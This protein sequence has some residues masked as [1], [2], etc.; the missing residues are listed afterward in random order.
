MKKLLFILLILMFASS[1]SATVYKWADEGGVMNFTDDYSK[2]PPDYR[3]KAEQVTVP[4]AARSTPS[5]ASSGNVAVAAPSGET[6]TQPP[7]IAQTLVR[8]GDFAIK[9]TKALKIG[10]AKNE[11][12][13]ESTLAS[14]GVTPQNGWIADYP[15]TPDIVGELENAI[16]VAA[17]S[18]KLGMKKD[19]ALKAFRTAAVELQLPIIAEIPNGYA[20]SSSPTTSQY[21]EPS[22]IDDYYDTEGPPVVTYYP[23][24]PDYYYMYAW[25]PS[26][27]WCSGFFFPGFFILHDFHRVIHRHGHAGIISNHIR[28]HRTGRFSAIDPVR[29]ASGTISGSR[30]TSTVRG[31]NSSE[32]RNGARAIFERSRARTGS[33][34][35][36]MPMAGKGSNDKNY[37]YSGSGRSN[38]KQ[39]YN[40]QRNRTGFSVRNGNS[41]RPPVNS[42]RMDRQYGM[43]FQRRPG[44][45]ARSFSPG[46]RDSA[47]SFGPSP[48][49]GGQHLGSS[50]T[51]GRGFS[52]SHQGGSHSG[53]S[54]RGSSRF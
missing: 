33:D 45:E 49:G 27:F 17:D 30:G 22:A 12:E 28:D 24:P 38:Q 6:A 23:P 43:S 51:G 53:G 10:Q 2:V 25:V 5:Q 37:A 32:A 52:G 47:R 29:R 1:A 44:G 15:V 34:I 36:S 13:A 42:Q 35:T 11:A 20:E 40:S 26:P 21:A 9:L 50:G 4:K 8:E 48:H 7:P 3:N 46:L 16:G 54:G 39:I 31:F 19:E 14:A 18:G 41:G